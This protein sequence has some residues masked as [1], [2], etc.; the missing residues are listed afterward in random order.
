MKSCNRPAWTR[1]E[2]E[3]KTI[4]A[5]RKCSTKC[6]SAAIE[7]Q[8]HIMAARELCSKR[9]A[10]WAHERYREAR[11]LYEGRKR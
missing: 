10:H 6:K 8:A 1:I 5:N 11:R 9:E 3:L 4:R 7:G 2:G